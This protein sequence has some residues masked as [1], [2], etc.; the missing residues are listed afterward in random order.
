MKDI[1]TRA[2]QA[3]LDEEYD[4][5]LHGDE[6]DAAEETIAEYSARDSQFFTL[7][8]EARARKRLLRELAEMRA[9]ANLTQQDVAQRM[10]T[11]QPAVARMETGGVD[12]R[13]STVQRYAASIGKR[14]RW[15]LVDP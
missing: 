14:L 15:Q 4:E 6:R 3:L 7:M 2:D 8:E 9:G 12:P 1:A 11:S 10:E 5:L 13:L